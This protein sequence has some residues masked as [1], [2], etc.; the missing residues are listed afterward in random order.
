MSVKQHLYK[1]TEKIAIGEG[2]VLSTML[3]PLAP[4][5]AQVNGSSIYAEPNGCGIHE[6]GEVR[7]GIQS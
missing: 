4:V 1:F 2:F 6:L 3:I 7:G 5:Y